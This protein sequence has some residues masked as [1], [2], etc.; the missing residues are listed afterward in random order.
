MC[1]Q[2]EVRH[3][4]IILT[5][6]FNNF[7]K[8]LLTD[9]RAFFWKKTLDSFEAK[10]GGS[11]LWKSNTKMW[12]KWSVTNKTVIF[13]TG[14]SSWLCCPQAPECVR[15]NATDLTDNGFMTE[16]NRGW[17]YV[18]HC[19]HHSQTEKWSAI[20]WKSIWNFVTF[21]HAICRPINIDTRQ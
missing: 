10:Y 11:T 9:R 16:A 17:S 19:Q 6:R 4:K 13:T 12:Q 7:F 5:L 2:I 14:Y 3:T 20:I 15:W 21:Y 8:I 1:R 18:R